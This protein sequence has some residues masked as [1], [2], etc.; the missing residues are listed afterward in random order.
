VHQTWKNTQVDTWPELVSDSVE[1]WLEH[2]VSTPMAYLL[3]DDEGIYRFL[4]EY[5]PRFIDQFSALPRMVEKSDVFRI[6]VSKYIGGIV[7]SLVLPIAWLV[8]LLTVVS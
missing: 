1:I 3:W 8:H 2:A 4:E 7:S 5:E 6:M